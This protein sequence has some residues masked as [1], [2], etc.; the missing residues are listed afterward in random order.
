MLQKNWP[1]L[2]GI[3]FC[4]MSVRRRC[5]RICAVLVVLEDAHA[6]LAESLFAELCEVGTKYPSQGVA[7]LIQVVVRGLCQ[8]TS[9]WGET[10]LFSLVS[11]LSPQK[12]FSAIWGTSCYLC[13]LSG[14]G[15]QVLLRCYRQSVCLSR[16]FF[17]MESLPGPSFFFL[18]L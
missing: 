5:R 2:K 13:I 10:F 12:T 8:G 7:H 17:S 18:N 9:S 3:R 11:K 1:G 14:G 6:M 16:P 4:G 15:S